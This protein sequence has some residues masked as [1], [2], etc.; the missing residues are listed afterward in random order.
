MALQQV[1]AILLALGLDTHGARPAKEKRM[2]D[3][4]GLRGQPQQ[5]A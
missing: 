1:N 5:V 3:H 2:R 4:I